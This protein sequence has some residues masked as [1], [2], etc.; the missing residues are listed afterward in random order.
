MVNVGHLNMPMTCYC[1]L[2][3]HI[4]LKF[5]FEGNLATDAIHDDHHLPQFDH[6]PSQAR[7][8]FCSSQ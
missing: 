4:V 6:P 3:I 2:D 5:A 7:C 1:F 8:P